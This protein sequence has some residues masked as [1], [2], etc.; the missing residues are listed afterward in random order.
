[1][2]Y[3]IAVIGTGYVGLVT[4][5]CFAE[6]G[7]DVI[8]VDIDQAKVE[9][10]RSGVVTIYEPGLDTIFE[11]NNREKRL[12]FTTNLEEAV[13]QAQIIFLCL[14][15]PPD[16]DGSAD[17]QYVLR[18]AADIGGILHKHNISAF[19][20]IVDK[21]TVPVGTSELV[22][23]QVRQAAPQA[24][25]EIV[26]NPEFLREGFA[27]E[28][29]MKPDRV[30]IGT[31]NPKAA[32]IM[33]DLYEP[34]TRSG[35][36][37]FIL[38]EKS[39]EVAKYAAN[40]FLA[41]RISFMNDLS[42]YCE[43]V[44][45]DIEDVRLAIG[46]DSRIGKRFLFAGVGYGGSCFPKDVRALLHSAEKEGIDLAIVRAVE[47]V[48]A[49][50][51]Q[52]FVQRII[53]RFKGNLSGKNFALWGIAFKPNTDDTR[54]AP[55]FYIIDELLAHGASVVCYDPEAMNGA[56]QRYGDMI[57]Y[58]NSRYDALQK[59]NALIIATEWN[60]FRNPNFDI[61]KAALQAPLIFD[62]RNLFDLD[63]M[64]DLGFEYH[65]IGRNVVK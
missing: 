53:E 5:T 32:A 62:G 12:T 31:S 56:K 52:R 46:S 22:R 41:M 16:E 44:G 55:A 20:V 45:A 11:R 13:L 63:K 38:D 4:G 35:N 30:V 26:S 47:E 48:N 10:L 61:I 57:G 24:Q 14:P 19:K 51:R 3:T 64:N 29:F 37:I 23:A 15:T 28:D 59:A 54:E 42:A 43:K 2:P 39:A 7:N 21:S 34:F 65:S 1:M 27:V 25:F 36:P 40:S 60:E 6:S 58:A 50:Q 9:K 17:L 8:C 49:R 18:S 33:K